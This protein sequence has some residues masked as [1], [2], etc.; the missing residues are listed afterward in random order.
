MVAVDA[1]VLRGLV[2]TGVSLASVITL[3]SDLVLCFERT[4]RSDIGTMLCRDVEMVSLLKMGNEYP[5]YGY[6]F[7]ENKGW[8]RVAKPRIPMVLS[9]AAGR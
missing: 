9:H 5:K 8:L 6:S 2:F 4:S 1:V 3:G 7:L